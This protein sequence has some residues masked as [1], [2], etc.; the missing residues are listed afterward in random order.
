VAGGYGSRL[1]PFGLRR[2]ET[3]T[4]VRAMAGRDAYAHSGYGGLRFSI[5]LTLPNR[6]PVNWFGDSYSLS[7][8][9]KAQGAPRLTY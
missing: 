7:I 6:R 4:P 2:A 8:H 1:R 9:H 3:P 5:V